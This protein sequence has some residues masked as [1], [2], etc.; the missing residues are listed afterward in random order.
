MGLVEERF[1]QRRQV[2]CLT[3]LGLW[4]TLEFH[5]SETYRDLYVYQWGPNIIL[6]YLTES[7]GSRSEY[8]I[9]V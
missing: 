2:E 4:Q 7:D 8:W 6:N 9:E 5:E 3:K 1:I